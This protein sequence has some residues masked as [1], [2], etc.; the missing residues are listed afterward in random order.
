[1]I[2]ISNTYCVIRLITNYGEEY[3]CYLFKETRSAYY[4]DIG[5]FL[6]SVISHIDYLTID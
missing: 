5:F 2:D 3:F 6:K 4:T 1:M